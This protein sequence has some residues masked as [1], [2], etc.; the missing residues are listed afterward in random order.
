[1]AITIKNLAHGQ[2]ANSKGTIYTVPASTTTVVKSIILVNTNTTAEA[3]NLYYY[4]ATASRRLIPVA[5]SLAASYSL[6]FECNI[7]MD[8]G[9]LIQGDTT[10]ASKVDFTISGVERT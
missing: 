4:K 3:V 5:L 6:T 10:T 1:M 8:T 2:L 9:D 7:T